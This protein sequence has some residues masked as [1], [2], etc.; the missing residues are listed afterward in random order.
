ML[1]VSMLS[2]IGVQELELFGDPLENLW[3]TCIF[4]FCGVERFTR[5]GEALRRIVGRTTQEP[6][7]ESRR[8]VHRA[9]RCSL[10][11][12]GPIV[13]GDAHHLVGQRL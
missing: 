6:L 12:L 10:G 3:K 5:R 1:S 7:V 4:G 2:A 8:Q 9:L 11:G 13:Q